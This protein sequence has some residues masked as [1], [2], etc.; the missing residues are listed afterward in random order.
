[1]KYFFLF[2]GMSS[3]LFTLSQERASAE[4]FEVQLK[5]LKW[6]HYY[7][8]DFKTPNRIVETECNEG[9][10]TT[11]IKFREEEI[12]F[13]S[14]IC[15]QIQYLDDKKYEQL[16]TSTEE[17][18]EAFIFFAPMLPK[19]KFL[20]EIGNQVFVVYKELNCNCYDPMC[21][22]KH[23]HAQ[24]CI[25]R[26]FTCEFGTLLSAQINGSRSYSNFHLME[27]EDAN[28]HVNAL[29]HFILTKKLFPFQQNN[30]LVQ[31]YLNR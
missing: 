14:D 19:E 7:M 11:H 15:T 10:V 20:V 28:A 1:M 22:S 25:E 12:Q 27:A 21:G 17:N 23:G 3:A 30:Q 26:Y 24:F 31:L 29:V 9:T 4:P 8:S 13:S 6:V 2:L 18:A 16:K 5:P